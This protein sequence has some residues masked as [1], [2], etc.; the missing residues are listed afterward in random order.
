MKWFQVLLF[1]VC[2]QWNYFKYYYLTLIILFNNNNN[3][4]YKTE[5]FYLTLTST[6]TPC[7]SGTE[8]NGNEWLLH[9]PQT[10]RLESHYQMQFNNNSPSY[11][12]EQFYLTLTSTTT[13]GKSGPE[14]NGNEWLL[15]IPQTLRL[16]SPYQMA[17]NNNSPSDNTEQFY[18]TQR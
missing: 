3:L 8:S 11:N 10:L 14:S 1:I 2:S 6:T 7:K 17:F 4:S 5:K 18:L 16:G 15:Y 13:P 12:T 9:I